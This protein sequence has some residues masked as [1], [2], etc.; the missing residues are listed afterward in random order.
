MTP[1]LFVFIS[2]FLLC[3]LCIVTKPLHISMTADTVFGSQKFHKGSIPRIG[4]AAI[5]LSLM[6]GSLFFSLPELMTIMM[7]ACLPVFVF[8]LIED[9]FKSVSSLYRLLAAL[10]SSVLFVYLS[11]KYFTSVDIFL[12]DQIFQALH[13]WPFLTVLALA[14]LI[15][16]INIID[17]FNGLAS[18]SSIFMG[19]AL[20]VLA[21]RYDDLVTVQMCLVF[22]AAVL[23]FFFINFPRGLLFLGDAGAYILGFFLGGISI[24]LIEQ[25]PE[26]TPLALLVVFAYPITELL[27]S[28]YRKSVR[29]GHRPDRPDRVHLHMLAYRKYGRRFGGSFFSANAVTGALFLFLPFSGL[30]V[31]ALMPVTRVIALLYFLIFVLAYL[32][33]YRRL[34]LRG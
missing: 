1:A 33:L 25:N 23:G 17:G 26:I 21:L 20:A 9:L 18:G 3:I 28:F 13:I 31:L 4:G 7:I 30:A 2:S 32:R 14:A 22:V 27:F 29:D 15:N 10:F 24:H 11:G 19:L 16:S 12:F 5:F 34:S 8:G 6:S